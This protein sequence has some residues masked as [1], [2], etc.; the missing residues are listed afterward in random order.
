MPIKLLKDPLEREFCGNIAHAER[1]SWPY[2]CC[3]FRHEFVRKVVKLGNTVAYEVVGNVSNV[4]DLLGHELVITVAN[5]GVCPF[6]RPSC[7]WHHYENCPSWKS[8]SL[9]K[10]RT[11]LAKNV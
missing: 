4:E 9:Y 3:T 11:K 8:W 10:L 2:W 7:P 5:V 1:P 6:W